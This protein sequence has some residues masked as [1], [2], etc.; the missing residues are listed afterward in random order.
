MI[1]AALSGLRVAIPVK[2]ISV[3]NNGGVSAIGTVSVQP[4]VSGLDGAGV[5]WPHGVISGVPYLRIQGGSNGVILDPAVGD[6]GIATVCDRD[7]SSVKASGGVSAPGSAR[8]NDLSDM[9]YLMSIIGPAPT[10][11]VEFSAA[12]IAL[13]SPTAVTINA[14]ATVINSTTFTV[15]SQTILNGPISQGTGAGGTNA[16]LIGPLAVTGDVT[17]GGK[18]L[19]HHTHS[20]VTTGGGNTGQPN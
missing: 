18:S 3:T 13:T 12:G 2:V 7:I 9:V 11:Y 10:Q 15:N 4:L 8:K 20:G 14:P 1:R 16:T 17:A 19:E 6:I 5:P